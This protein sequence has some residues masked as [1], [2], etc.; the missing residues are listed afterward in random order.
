MIIRSILFS[1][2]NNL[3]RELKIG[4]DSNIDGLEIRLDSLPSELP[5]A[6]IV[7]SYPGLKIL[8]LKNEAPSLLETDPEI[9]EDYDMI[10]LDY[11]YFISHRKDIGIPPD[12]LL[13]SIHTSSKKEIRN[14]IRDGSVSAYKLKIV[15]KRGNLR[16]Y[17]ELRNE[18]SNLNATFFRMGEKYKITRFYAIK[19]E[20]INYSY[21]GR[22]TAPGQFS[23]EEAIKI[24]NYEVYGLVGNPLTKSLSKMIYD[25]I[26]SRYGIKAIYLNFEINPMDFDYFIKIAREVGIAGLNFTVPFKL[27]ASRMF[28]D[29]IHPVNFVKLKGNVEIRN[30]DLEAI[31]YLIG[32][33]KPEKVLIYGNGASA[34]TSIMAFPNSEL[35][36]IGRNLDKVKVFSNKYG[37]KIA[38][39]PAEFDVLINS[40]PV[41]M[42]QA[43]KLPD[44]ISD[45]VFDAIID[46]PYSEDKTVFQEFAERRNIQFISGK[47]IL[48]TQASFNIKYWFGLQVSPKEILE[49]LE[50]DDHGSS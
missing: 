14:L 49:I 41:G 38:E 2:N 46:F 21:V 30:T 11:R 48:A 37:A 33:K 50:G 42:Y 5:D 40:T 7:A 32:N 27:D 31:K 4:S 18:I 8:T 44:I 9:T 28:H 12:K 29:G 1:N 39:Q 6:E 15:L 47:Q 25:K 19:G 36:V 17:Y 10:D 35:Y 23:I 16:D 22:K 20:G 3:R 26:F 34:I 43:G 24:K 13:I 45:S